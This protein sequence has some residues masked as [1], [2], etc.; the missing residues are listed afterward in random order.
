MSI[1]SSSARRRN[2]PNLISPLQR[3]H[4]FGVR[5]ASCSATKSSITV[6]ANSSDRSTISNGI[7]AIRATSA[8]SARAAGPQHPCSTPSRCTR[9]M[10]EP[11]TSYPCS[12]SRHAATDESTPPD[13][14]TST[15]GMHGGYRAGRRISPAGILGPA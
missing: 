5:P 1:P 3:A 6:A 7:P 15:E 14:A 10:C 2:A 4:G 9:F 12:L 13:I 11:T 8:A